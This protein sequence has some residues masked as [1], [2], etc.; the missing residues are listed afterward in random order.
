MQIANFAAGLSP[1]RNTSA[2]QTARPAPAAPKPQAS[3]GPTPQLALQGSTESD[4]HSSI[5]KAITRVAAW[6]EGMFATLRTPAQRQLLTEFIRCANVKRPNAEIW[7]SNLT[8]SLRMSVSVAT[9]KRGVKE[10]QQ[11][12]WIRREQSRSRQNKF[13]GSLTLLSDTAIDSL[14]LRQSAPSPIASPFPASPIFFRGSEVSPTIGDHGIQSSSKRQ[15]AQK[16]APGPLKVAT[17]QAP[18]TPAA[19]ESV[20]AQIPTAGLSE[21]QPQEPSAPSD[22]GS[23][24]RQT[25]KPGKHPDAYLVPMAL[26]PLLARLNR[27][28]IYRLM[29]DARKKKTMLEFVTTLNEEHILAARYPIAYI[30]KLLASNKDW[31]FLHGRSTREAK[32]ALTAQLEVQELR[33]QKEAAQA[34]VNEHQGQY[35]QSTSSGKVY[36]LDRIAAQCW[37]PGGPGRGAQSG[38]VADVAGLKRGITENKLLAIDGDQ[39]AQAIAAMHT[40]AAAPRSRAGI[41]GPQ[42]LR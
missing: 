10:L 39:A 12:G 7:I 6:R 14:G 13:S 23:V 24:T 9:I 28:Q 20:Q 21:K 29:G 2:H 1:A 33:H 27:F 31:A 36:L 15:P 16:T 4:L 22:G 25:P 8:L 26:A 34:F 38:V 3:T 41:A 5:S 37:W 18:E 40:P 11:G 30:R 32:E 19:T 42:P 35:F 17:A